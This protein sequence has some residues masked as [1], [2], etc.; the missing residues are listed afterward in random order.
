MEVLIHRKKVTNFP[1]NIAEI[2]AWQF[3]NIGVMS[4]RHQLLCVLFSLR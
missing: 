1:P 4:V 3:G 2:F